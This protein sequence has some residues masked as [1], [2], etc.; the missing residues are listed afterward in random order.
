MSNSSKQRSFLKDLLRE[1][2]VQGEEHDINVSV[3]T[4]KHSKV[5]LS[6]GSKRQSVTISSTPRN[7]SVAQRAALADIRR[8][9]SELN[10]LA[11]SNFD[12]RGILQMLSDSSTTDETFNS[13]LDSNLDKLRESLEVELDK[14]DVSDVVSLIETM[15]SPNLNR[16]SVSLGI[17]QSVV[18]SILSPGQPNPHHPVACQRIVGVKAVEK[19]LFGNHFTLRQAIESLLDYY[20]HCSKTTRI[21]VIVTDIWRPSDIGRA[22]FEFDYWD[23]NGV[24]TLFVLACGKGI[25]VLD[26]P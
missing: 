21:G 4:G 14:A 7:R 10:P 16:N 2:K 23:V 11:A 25:H 3:E 20:S 18:S 1:L 15:L 12:G 17:N 13:S 9:L 24:K 26:R 5:V 8:A 19:P 22:S 6:S